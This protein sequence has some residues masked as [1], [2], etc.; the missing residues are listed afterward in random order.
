MSLPVRGVRHAVVELI[1]WVHVELEGGAQW[2]LNV[3]V[4]ALL[5]LHSHVFVVVLRA[6]LLVELIVLLRGI[7]TLN[8]LC[9]C[10]WHRRASFAPKRFKYG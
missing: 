1:A 4:Q 3:R 8:I 10:C 6:Q 9:G 7:E 2:R 5:H